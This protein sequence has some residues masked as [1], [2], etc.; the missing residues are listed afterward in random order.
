MPNPPR[1]PSSSAG[2]ILS[3]RLSTA[4]HSRL[5]ELTRARGVDSS[6][7][8]RAWI[9]AGCPT[10]ALPSPD[11][12]PREKN[13]PPRWAMLAGDDRTIIEAFQ[14]RSAQSP[15]GFAVF[16]DVILDVMHTGLDRRAI[17]VRISL[18]VEDQWID[19]TF[20]DNA[21]QE[22]ATEANGYRFVFGCLSAYAL[23]RVSPFGKR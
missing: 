10:S 22:N 11:A 15:H 4:E 14:A 12:S 20:A 8:V 2:H 16:E 9:A 1:S 17:L 18:M 5:A 23:E 3:V 7:L 19:R 21:S 6:T 13:T